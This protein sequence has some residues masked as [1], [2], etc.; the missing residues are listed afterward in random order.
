[1]KQPDFIRTLCAAI[2]SFM[3]LPAN[4]ALL[5]RL[6]ATP[7]GTDYQAYYD[8]LLDITW[9]ANANLNGLDTSWGSQTTWANSLTI[10]GVSGWRLPSADVNGDGVVVDCTGGGVIDCMDNEMGFLY[11]EESITSATP[12]PFSNVQ[13]LGYWSDTESATDPA[14]AWGFSFSSG[15][16][17]ADDKSNTNGYAWAVHSGDV[18]A[19]PAPAAIVLFSSGLLG[20]IGMARR[21]QA[22]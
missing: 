22:A 19:V 9:A 13:F 20:L 15:G 21:K 17:G 3:T 2:L 6:P 8:P 7:G 1:M 5:G 12:G 10:G 11:W 4:A 18:A 14:S 16:Q